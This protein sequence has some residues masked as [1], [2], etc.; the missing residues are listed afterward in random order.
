MTTPLPG[1]GTN[2]DDYIA[3]VSNSANYLLVLMQAGVANAQSDLQAA[4]VESQVAVTVGQLLMSYLSW[5]NDESKAIYDGG[6]KKSDKSDSVY[7]NGQFDPGMANN[8]QATSA[9][10]Q[11]FTS[12]AQN[13]EM[14]TKNVATTNANSANNMQQ[15]SQMS[16]Q[17]TDISQQE[18]NLASLL[19]APD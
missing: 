12:A 19:G 10:M 14:L 18:N 6:N 9:L 5:A 2:H 3:K 15:Q 11:E 13:Y 7:Y 8:D 16:L 4:A 17:S 1:P